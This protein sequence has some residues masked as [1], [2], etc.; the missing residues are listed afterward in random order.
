MLLSWGGKGEATDWRPEILLS[1]KLHRKHAEGRAVR[2]QVRSSPVG[3][4]LCHSARTWNRAKGTLIPVHVMK[5]GGSEG[6]APLI[7]NLG[8][9]WKWVL[10]F[11]LQ[12]LYAKTKTRRYIT[13]VEWATQPEWTFWRTENFLTGLE[14]DPGEPSTQQAA[15]RPA[16]AVWQSTVVLEMTIR[17]RW[18]PPAYPL[19]EL[20]TTARP[21]WDIM[22][23]LRVSE[24]MW[25]ATLA[26]ADMAHCV[27]HTCM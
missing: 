6:T 5:H 4:A 13:E 19:V 16:S 22:A 14:F 26:Q 8:T 10:S 18:Q 17:M 24:S 15:F 1:S 23:K 3:T 7:L 11:R 2:T 12:L 21:S 25:H 20:L 9:T 27:K